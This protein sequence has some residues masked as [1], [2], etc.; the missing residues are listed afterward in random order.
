MNDRARQSIR[1]TIGEALFNALALAAPRRLTPL[2]HGWRVFHGAQQIASGYTSDNAPW[3]TVEFV[4]NQDLLAEL[5]SEREVMMRWLGHQKHRFGGQAP[6][7]HQRGNPVDWFRLGFSSDDDAL[8]FLDEFARQRRQAQV[9][10]RWA[11]PYGE[12]MGMAP[13]APGPAKVE[14]APTQAVTAVV[15][16]S[17]RVLPAGAAHEEREEVEPDG[18]ADRGEGDER[19]EGIEEHAGNV[20]NEDYALACIPVLVDH[21][22]RQK[23]DVMETLT[24]EDLAGR[25]GR[26]DK[27]H[28]PVSIGMGKILGLAMG[29]VDRATAG[30]DEPPYLTTIVV[31]KSRQDKGLP[32]VG[33][34]E[35]W[36]G[37]DMFTR[38]E[39]FAR[40]GVEYQRI[41]QY[42]S[43][44]NEVLK[45]LGMWPCSAAE[46]RSTHEAGAARG[47]GWGGGESAEHKALK[48]YVRTHPEL[49]GAE[50]DDRIWRATE[51]YALRSEDVI[52]VFF[53]S[54]NAW[55]GVE[56]KSAVSDG[57]PKDYERG[58]YQVVK[59]QA[60]LAAQARIDH[61]AAPPTV[62][63]VL[64]L[65]STLPLLLRAVAQTLEVQV[66]DNLRLVERRAAGAD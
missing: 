7:I 32:G 5:P 52:D 8:T 21:V 28:H 48:E 33:V 13:P 6:K 2:D 39:K 44:W 30:M 4:F 64:A 26:L 66:V 46:T 22:L 9:S 34:R 62:K 56:V 57:N 11:I 24:Y 15:A 17:K 12:A 16:L 40:V 49:F 18:R 60:V 19:D 38:P 10:A 51:E 58:L 27:Y 35:R 63:V 61:P 25:L 42:G 65:D 37:Y 41:L 54:N 53:K 45:A 31:A 36:H 23:D 59:Y 55:I 50:A 29:H 14:V 43:R 1:A 47:D 3:H 20:S